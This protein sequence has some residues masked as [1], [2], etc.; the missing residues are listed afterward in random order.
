MHTFLHLSDSGFWKGGASNSVVQERE[1]S[2]SVVWEG[3][4]S[5][6]VVQEGEA[7]DSVVWEGGSASLL[8]PVPPPSPSG[9]WFPLPRWLVL[10]LQYYRSTSRLYRDSPALSAGARES[11]IGSSSE[12]Q[13][14]RPP[15]LPCRQCLAPLSFLSTL[16]PRKRPRLG[17]GLT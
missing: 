14:R 8:V 16:C 4:V 2:D 9:L 17:L 13:G 10:W 6:S 7:S 3:E 11:K 5:D 12:S 15:T 1:A